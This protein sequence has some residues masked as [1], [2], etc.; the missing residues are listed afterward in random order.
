ME[1]S[2]FLG[3]DHFSL[4]GLLLPIA[5]DDGLAQK[6]WEVLLTRKTPTLPTSKSVTNSYLLH[7]YQPLLWRHPLCVLHNLI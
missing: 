7:N 5:H 1:M 6:V 3:F 4:R 2:V